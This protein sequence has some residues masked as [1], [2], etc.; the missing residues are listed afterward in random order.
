MA[1]SRARDAVTFVRAAG[2]IVARDGD[3]LLVHRPRYDDWTF[4]KGKAE[5]GETDEDC[6]LREVH[7]ETGLRCALDD[8]VAVTE[9]VDSMGRPKRVRWWRMRPLADDGF[10]P[11]DE[12]DELRWVDGETARELLTYERDRALAP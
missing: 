2:G 12:V 10:T 1:A 6:A 3:V 11:N 8:E 9:Y 7:E 5:D 4:P